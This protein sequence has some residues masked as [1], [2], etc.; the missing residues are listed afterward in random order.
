MQVE[1][2]F[3]IA[4]FADTSWMVK[5]SYVFVSSKEF[6]RDWQKK[7]KKESDSHELAASF[8]VWICHEP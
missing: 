5:S 1:K 2:E 3:S 4:A 7:R 8:K 6:K